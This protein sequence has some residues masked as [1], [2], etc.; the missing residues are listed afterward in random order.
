MLVIVYQPPSRVF[1]V[2]PRIRIAEPTPYCEPQTL[3]SI[4]VIV[5]FV[6]LKLTSNSS[7]SASSQATSARSA[8]ASATRS[9]SSKSPSRTTIRSPVVMPTLP[10]GTRIVMLAGF[11]VAGLHGSSSVSVAPSQPMF[12]SS[13]VALVST[14]VFIMPPA[15]A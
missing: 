9:S 14:V 2:L 11:I 7:C 8:A 13:R 15:I 6:L 4:R 1:S 10:F 12:G 5:R 3:P